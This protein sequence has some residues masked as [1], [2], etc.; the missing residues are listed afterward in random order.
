MQN[1]PLSSPRSALLVTVTVAVPP[2]W[3]FFLSFLLFFDGVASLG[4][5]ICLSIPA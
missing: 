3:H 1:M 5:R 2:T 4:M